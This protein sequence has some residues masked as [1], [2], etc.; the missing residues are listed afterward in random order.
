MRVVVDFGRCEGHGLC[1]GEAPDVFDVDEE[2]NLQVLAGSPDE[3]MRAALEAAVMC[4][5]TGALTVL[6]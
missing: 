3:N 4:C 1:V 5:P 6:D 2:N